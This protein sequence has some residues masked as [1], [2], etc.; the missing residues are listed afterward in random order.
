M[1]VYIGYKRIDKRELCY[2]LDMRERC[3]WRIRRERGEHEGEVCYYGSE[4]SDNE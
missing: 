4:G 1:Q 3:D 2:R